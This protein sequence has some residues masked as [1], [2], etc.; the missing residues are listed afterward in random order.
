MFKTVAQSSGL[1]VKNVIF[2]SSIIPGGAIFLVQIPI[3]LI[4]WYIFFK[5]TKIIIYNNIQNTLYPK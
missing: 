2:Y 4:V 3:I 5:Y 1:P